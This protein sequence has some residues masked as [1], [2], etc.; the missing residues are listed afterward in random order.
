MHRHSRLISNSRRVALAAVCAVVGSFVWAQ[1][2]GLGS[3]ESTA[4][5]TFQD[6]G[7]LPRALSVELTDALYSG[8]AADGRHMVNGAPLALRQRN[9]RD[10]LEE[11]LAS[12]GQAGAQ[13]FLIG[14]LVHFDGATV[15]YRLTSYRVHP[16]TPLRSQVFSRTVALAGSRALADGFAQDITALGGVRRAAGTIFR[17]EGGI[18]ADVGAAQGFRLG[19]RFNEF[20]NG[21]VVAKLQIASID[22]AAATLVVTSAPPDFKPAMGDRVESTERESVTPPTQSTA[23]HFNPLAIA[24]AA[25][26]ALIAVGHHG[27]PAAP[28]GPPATPTPGPSP[29]TVQEGAPAGTPPNVTFSFVFSQP[30]NVAAGNPATNSSLASYTSS[31][32][33]NASFPLNGLGTPSFDSTN[34]ILTIIST[35]VQPGETITFTF[36]SQIVDAAGDHLTATS[37]ANQFST[38]RHPLLKQAPKAVPVPA[39]P[40]RVFPGAPHG[41]A[42]VRPQPPTSS[43]RAPSNPSE[44]LQG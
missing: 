41:H 33:G 39:L 24:L 27:E 32:T 30:V 28:S 38:T 11:A 43:V 26:A 35:A 19:E 3:S 22:S 31:L 10:S 13:D 4:V 25:A 5:F 9:D 14:D 42:P 12:A 37:F 2:P 17:V 6:H 44:A 18:R 7:Q 36:S 34:T 21:V 23:S 29:F 20:H 15:V 40:P 1:T 16:L 8:A